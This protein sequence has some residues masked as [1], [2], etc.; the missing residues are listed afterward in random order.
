MVLTPKSVAGGQFNKITDQNWELNI[1]LRRQ[2][3]GEAVQIHQINSLMLV[4]KSISRW[5]DPT[6]VGS[7]QFVP[8]D[9]LW[10]G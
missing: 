6:I 3:N 10:I 9:Y 8:S 5:Y 7:T 1:D 4:H 2:V